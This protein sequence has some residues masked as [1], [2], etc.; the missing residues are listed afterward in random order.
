MKTGVSDVY[1][2]NI[3]GVGYALYNQGS[4]FSSDGHKWI[5]D[6]TSANKTGGFNI[7]GV[8]FT[9]RLVKIGDITSGSLVT[10]QY[11][12]WSYYA[13]SPVGKFYITSGKVTQLACSISSPNIVIPL[14]D[15]PTSDFDGTIGPERDKVGTQNMV[16]DCDANANVN[17][18]L[19]AVK[20]P[21]TSDNSVLTLDG[22]GQSGTATGVGV[23]LLYN[24]AP[25]EI[26]KTLML[27]S[28][29]GGKENFPISARYFQTKPVVTS[30]NA[31]AS[32]TLTLTYQ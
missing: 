5:N 11:A 3:P 32:A 8:D 17:V 4:D 28:A 26:N 10:G 30:G 20:N 25:L 21:D 16:L 24:N 27:K 6:Y 12:S 18:M 9:L 7:N 15:I 13:S 23:Q 2:T 1:K 14:G 31:N 19:K 29:I 22:Q